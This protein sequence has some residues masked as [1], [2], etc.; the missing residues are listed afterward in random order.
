[1]SWQ[2][3][4]WQVLRCDGDVPHGQCPRVLY[5][6]DADPAISPFAWGPDGQHVVL[7]ILFTDADTD[8]NPRALQEQG[9]MRTRTR[10]LCP[11]HVAALEHMA[12][13]EMEGLPFDV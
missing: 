5:D 7:P 10:V 13:A 12:E 8:V 4:T 1:M 11:D 3:M 9:W 2:A 6:T